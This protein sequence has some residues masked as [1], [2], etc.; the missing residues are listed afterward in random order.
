MLAIS[1]GGKWLSPLIVTLAVL[2][3]FVSNTMHA[4]FTNR[5]SAKLVLEYGIVS[6]VCE[7]LMLNYV[8]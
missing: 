3:Y 6:L 1:Q 4:Y 7:L 5:L 2:G 8:I